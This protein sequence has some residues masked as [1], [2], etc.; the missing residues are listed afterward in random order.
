MIPK[1]TVPTY[2]VTLPS[3]GQKVRI[4]PFLVKEEKLLLMAIESNDNDEIIRTTIDIIQNC[5]QTKDVDIEKLPFFDVDYLFI[6]L[7]AKSVGESI[8][9]K[10]HCNS[11][12]NGFICGNEFKAAIDISNCGIRKNEAIGTSINLGQGLTVKMHYPSYTE[13]KKINSQDS[14]D[15]LTHAIIA[16]CMDMMVQGDNVYTRKDF[17]TEI[18]EFLGGLT[19]DQYAKLVKWSDNLPTFYVKA[20][21]K[22]DK[23]G[24]DHKLE[25][26]EFE[27]FFV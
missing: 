1:L 17:E 6:A 14:S 8:D 20:E 22:C 25:Y 18:D 27:S 12:H 7:R 3:N 24:F 21:A 13:M 10:F 9:V 16:K 5:I 11:S 26:E 4:R 15:D 23:C 2:E 19:K